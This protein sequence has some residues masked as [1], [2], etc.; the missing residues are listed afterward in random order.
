MLLS[1]DSLEA[2]DVLPMTTQERLCKWRTKVAEQEVDDFVAS[3]HAKSLHPD[4]FLRRRELFFFH[5]F[6]DFSI[7]AAAFYPSF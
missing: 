1:R 5:T 4:N 3:F 2:E 7:F 6:S